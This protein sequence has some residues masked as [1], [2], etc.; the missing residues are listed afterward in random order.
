MN[1]NAIAG[2]AALLSA[3]GV[4]ASVV[5]LA[6]Q[7][8]QSMK[9]S[10]ASQNRSIMESYEGFN[11][12]ILG[13]SD[14][15]A[16]L[17]QLE[18]DDSELSRADYIRARHLAYRMMNLWTSAEFSYLNMQLGADEFAIYQLDVKNTI[19]QYPGL[20]PPLIENLRRYP[21]MKQFKVYKVLSERNLLN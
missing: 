16:L 13:S 10:R 2:A 6:R 18:N 12:L 4:A 3:I 11:S 14:A 20:V 21:A 17:I 1:W 8:G 19:D 7:I 5:Y 15:V 9:L